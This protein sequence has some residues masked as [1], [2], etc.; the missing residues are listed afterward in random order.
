MPT[1]KIE[2]AGN[3][4]S[5]IIKT[6]KQ[7]FCDLLDSGAEVSLIHTRV[8]NSLKQKPKLKKQSAFLQSIKDDSIH[9]DGCASLKY[10]IGREK[11]EHEYL[12]STRNEQKHYIG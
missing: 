12:C 2:L 8:Y 1:F 4:N 7:K 3:P 5:C 9:L 11:Q 10:E 6:N